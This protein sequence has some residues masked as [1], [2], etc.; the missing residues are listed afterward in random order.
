MRLRSRLLSA[1]QGAIAAT[2]QRGGLTGAALL[3]G[4]VI[5]MSTTLALNPFNSR[6]QVVNAN[7]TLALDMVPTG[8]DYC[9]GAGLEPDGVT[10]CSPANSMSVGAVDSCLADAAGN[11]NL[12]THIAHVIVQNV[13][14]MIG[15]QARLNYDGGMM[16]PN[17]VQFTPFTD[18]NTL[19]GVSFVNLPIDSGS[20]THRDITAAVFI[21]PGSPGP[22]TAAFGS[23]YLGTVAAAISSDTPPKS[24]PD[25]VS[26]SAPNGG[27]LAALM[28]R[29]SP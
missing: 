26:Y 19:Q 16:R 25:D 17:S 18:S 11:N 5:A 29:W 28:T 15:W 7:T 10:P 21:P 8:N 14:D 9:D 4:L 22:Q 1:H 20:S 6:A 2:H 3:F 23:S 12:H 27:I 24:T 13:E